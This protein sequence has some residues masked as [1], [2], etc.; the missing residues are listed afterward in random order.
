MLGINENGEKAL[1]SLSLPSLSAFITAYSTPHRSFKIVDRNF[2]KLIQFP[3][4]GRGQGYA[5][6]RWLL[7]EMLHEGLKEGE[8]E[9]R[10]GGVKIEW[11]KRL[12][13]YEESEEGV[14]AYFDDGTQAHGDVLVGA[15]GAR[16][17]VRKQRTDKIVYP[18]SFSLSLSLPSLSLL[19]LTSLC[20][21]ASSLSLHLINTQV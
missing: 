15:D 12:E 7:R 11:G 8:G 3:L 2:A 5:I 20:A 18:P 21:S 16:S 19:P 13:R 1:L 6:N 14:V 4:G 17:R 9:E 10:E